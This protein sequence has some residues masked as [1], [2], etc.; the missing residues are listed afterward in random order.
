MSKM[1]VPVEFL[2]GTTIEV[3]IAEA[4]DKAL[5]WKVAYVTFSFNG[6]RVSISST[7]DVDK[8]KNDFTNI[9]NGSVTQTGVIG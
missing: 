3:A 7:A 8:A 5:L 9:C 1:L 6:L 4:K 2:P